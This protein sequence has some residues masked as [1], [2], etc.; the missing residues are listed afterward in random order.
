MKE[1]SV[2][3]K[4]NKDV[5]ME[6]AATVTINPLTALRMLEDFGNLN[7][8]MSLVLKNCNFFYMCFPD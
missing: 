4:I 3:H 7:P 5:P 8:G 1:Q 2:W 6:Y